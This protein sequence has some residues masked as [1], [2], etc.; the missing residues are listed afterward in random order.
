MIITPQAGTEVAIQ[1]RQGRSDL[2][3]LE[4]ARETL[5]SKIPQ[6][7]LLQNQELES[8]AV[9]AYWMTY[10]QLFSSGFELIKTIKVSPWIRIHEAALLDEDTRR[11]RPV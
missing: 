11:W 10:I 5:G 3:R 2:Q 9:W 4:L 7:K 6:I 8:E 1:F